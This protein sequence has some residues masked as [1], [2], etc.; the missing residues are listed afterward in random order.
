M[1]STCAIYNDSPS[2]YLFL[3]LFKRLEIHKTTVVGHFQP[4]LKAVDLI[5]NFHSLVVVIF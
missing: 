1:G 2:F 5:I 3:W 4:A